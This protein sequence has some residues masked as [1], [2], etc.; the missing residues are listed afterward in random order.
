MSSFL[1]NNWV[2]WLTVFLLIAIVIVVVKSKPRINDITTDFEE[3]PSF[4]VLAEQFPQRKYAYPKSFV[5]Q[6]REY[7]AHIQ[8]LDVSQDSEEVFRHVLEVVR[9]LQWN[10]VAHSQEKLKLE[11]TVVTKWLRF[12]DDVVIE[13]RRGENPETSLVHVRS[14]SRLGKSDF[15]VNAKR[16]QAFFVRLQSKI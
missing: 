11:A 14:R 4:E 12:K 16:I 15:G 10:V 13:V 8:P 7:Y 2:T 9:E 1:Q 6:Q 3:P 5:E